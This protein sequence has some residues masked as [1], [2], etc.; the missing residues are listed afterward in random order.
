MGKMTAK[1]R[2]SC[3]AER[4][5]KMQALPGA[6]CCC[7]LHSNLSVLTVA[8]DCVHCHSFLLRQKKS[9]CSQADIYQRRD[10]KI[11][12]YGRFQRLLSSAAPFP[13]L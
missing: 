2:S 12:T 4:D 7:S 1:S 9:K 8:L 6:D 10:E 11:I 13:F 3:S 5:R